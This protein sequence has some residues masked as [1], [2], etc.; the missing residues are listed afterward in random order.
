MPSLV[1]HYLFGQDILELVDE[2]C[3]RH[4]GLSEGAFRLGLQG[5]DIFFYDPI[6]T[7]IAGDKQIGSKMHKTR[8]DIYFYKFIQYV[9]ENHLADNSTIRAYFY[10]ILCHYCLD[11]TAHPFIYSMTDQHI[12][13]TAG[14]RLSLSLHCQLE[15]NIDELLYQERCHESISKRKRSDFFQISQK[16]QSII[17]PAIAQAVSE[18]YK[19]DISERYIR[20]TICRAK[21]SNCLLQDSFGL[22]KHLFGCL[23]FQLTKSHVLTSLIFHTKLPAGDFMNLNH[24]E[25]L[26]PYNKESCT[27]S[28]KDLYQ[29][30]VKEAVTLINM[31]DAVFEG[32]SSISIFVTETKGLSYHTGQPWRYN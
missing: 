5:P 32:K 16:E 9:K 30:A 20:G 29:N 31:A 23:E 24:K 10:G 18:T 7:L 4:I 17:A 2:S 26:I 6:Q 28:F 27:L 11:Y 3:I 1:T 13:G 25:W 8:S 19:C 21:I 22:K 15:S 12:D 14:K